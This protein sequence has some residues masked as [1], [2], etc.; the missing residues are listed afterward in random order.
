MAELRPAAFRDLVTR[1]YKEAERQDAIFELPRRSWYLPEA[2]T[3]DMSVYFHGRKAGN[4]SGPASGPQTQ[5]AQNLAICYLAGAR[6]MEL[7]TVQVLDRLD[8]PRPCIDMT[9]VDYNIEWS[10]ELL[11]EESL[12]EYVA[13]MMLVEMV[14]RAHPEFRGIHSAPSGDVVYD[15]SLGYD[16][17]GIKSGKVQGYLDSMRDASSVIEK[18]RKEIPGEFAEAR[19][20]DFPKMISSSV[21]LSTFHGCPTDEIERIVEFLLGERGLDVTVKMNP[22]TL[23]KE[24]LEYLLHDVLGYASIRV[25]PSAYAA[26]QSFDEAV[27]MARRLESFAAVRGR[28]FGCKFSNTLEV[29]NHRDF[30]PKGNET[31]YLSGSALHVV[32]MALT[33]RFRRAVGPELP[34]SFSAGIDKTNF[35]D[36]VACGFVPVTACSDLLKPGGYGRLPLYLRGLEKEMARRGA[37]DIEGFQAAYASEVRKRLENAPDDVELVNTVY[38]ARK[39]REDR[40]YA[41]EANSAVP[42]RIDSHLELFDCISCDKCLP[43]CPNAANFVYPSPGLECVYTDFVVTEEGYEAGEEKEFK[44]TKKHQIAN[45]ADFCNECGN[46]DTFCPEYGGPYIEKPSFYLRAESFAAD[47]PRDGFLVQCGRESRTLEGRVKGEACRLVHHQAANEFHFESRG[48]TVVFDED[49]KLISANGYAHGTRIDSGLFL[50]LRA[51]LEGVL[52]PSHLNQVNAPLATG[53]P[54]AD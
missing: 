42:K 10:Q 33:D 1:L 50:M 52:D 47:A 48:G 18:L 22:P 44:L 11:I 13:G 49:N 27:D 16:L 26:S 43:V 40:R 53:Q 15:I 20:L 41:A 46:C 3:P 6:I 25:K 24:E 23:G 7:K 28:R 21:T 34:I 36:A 54:D 35:P 8:I 38:V 19:V 51:L 5:M 29:E 2:D 4:P 37:R 31:M 9:N 12:Q 32:T 45:F 30:F 17:E 39:A 14:R